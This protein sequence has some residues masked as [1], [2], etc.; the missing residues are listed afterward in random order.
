MDLVIIPDNQ[1]NMDISLLKNHDLSITE[2]R[3]I[4]LQLFLKAKGALSQSDIE[5]KTRTNLDRVTVYRTLQTFLDK[6]LVHL[7]PN[8]DNTLLYAL[9][10]DECST[11]KHQH[12][13]VHFLC[14][15][16]DHTTCIE[17][18]TVPA[19]KLPKGFKLTKSSMIIEGLCQNCH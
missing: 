8:T 15:N 14:T 17:E 11:G 10:G 7:I 19:V 13:H 4:I 12:D 9:C 2:N 16:C 18:V 1:F 3:K 5:K 6:G